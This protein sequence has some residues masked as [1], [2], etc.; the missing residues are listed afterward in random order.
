[1]EKT[2]IT[3]KM[4]MMQPMRIWIPVCMEIKMNMGKIMS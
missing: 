2:M 1:M 4:G 3:R